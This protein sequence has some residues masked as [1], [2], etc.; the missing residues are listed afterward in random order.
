MYILY[1]YQ[2]IQQ[3]TC[4]V[5]CIRYMMKFQTEYLLYTKYVKLIIFYASARIICA[6]E[7]NAIQNIKS[8]YTSN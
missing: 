8:D 4:K 2:Y 5:Y 3:T 6:A 1:K 7:M